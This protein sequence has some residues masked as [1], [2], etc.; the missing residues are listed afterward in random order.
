MEVV[1]GG[2]NGG[3]WVQRWCWVEVRCGGHGGLGEKWSWKFAW[4]RKEKK[5]KKSD[6]RNSWGATSKKWIVIISKTKF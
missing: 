1:L 4:E 5:D 3:V 2:C 6:I